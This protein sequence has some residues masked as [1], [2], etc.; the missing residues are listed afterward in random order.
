[1]FGDL[2]HLQIVSTGNLLG[3]Q[4]NPCITPEF[5]SLLNPCLGMLWMLEAGYSMNKE[6]IEYF[7]LNKH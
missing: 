3:P 7:F 4:N 5:V 6:L 2:L 1:M